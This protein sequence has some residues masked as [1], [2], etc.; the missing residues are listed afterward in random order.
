M[1]RQKLDFKH[2]KKQVPEEK[3]KEEDYFHIEIWH[4]ISNSKM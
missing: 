3:L 4:M 2:H 1:S